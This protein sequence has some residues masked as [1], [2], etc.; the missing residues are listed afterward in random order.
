MRFTIS[1]VLQFLGFMLTAALMFANLKGDL[2]E[3][4]A[5]VGGRFEAQEYRIGVLEHRRR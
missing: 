3:L 1:Q 5:Q 2:R 4:K